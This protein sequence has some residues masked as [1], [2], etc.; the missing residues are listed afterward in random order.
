[1]LNLGIQELLATAL[2][3]AP[4][5]T[6]LVVVIRKAFKITKRFIP[7]VAVVIGIVVGLLVVDFSIS[8]AIAGVIFGL[9]SV[10]LWEVGRTSVA[11][12]SNSTKN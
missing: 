9:S 3:A 11:N 10:G 12:I 6:G 7:L 5:I 2:F 4:L 8:G 1:M